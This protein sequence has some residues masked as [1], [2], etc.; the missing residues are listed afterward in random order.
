MMTNTSMTIYNRYVD[1]ITRLDKWQRHNLNFV[2]WDASSGVSISKGMSQ[3][4]NVDVYIP[5]N[6]NYMT[7]YTYPI[8]FKLNPVGYWTIQNGDIIVKG[9]ITDEI[10][11]AS[12]LERKYN[13]VYTVQNVTENFYG[14]PNM[15]HVY[16][17][18]A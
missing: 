10:T 9:N 2:Y 4:S 7:Y 5:T 1:P 8:N 16:I 14:S 6:M 15:Q 12:D 11:K 18:G 17:R 3:N 13:N